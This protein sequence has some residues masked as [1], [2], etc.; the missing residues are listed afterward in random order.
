MD[1]SKKELTDSVDF[2]GYTDT[3]DSRINYTYA[4][5]KNAKTGG[6][7]YGIRVTRHLNFKGGESEVGDWAVVSESEFLSAKNM[8]R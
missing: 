8:K 5:F 6:F 7:V 3:D 4:K 2:T 1:I